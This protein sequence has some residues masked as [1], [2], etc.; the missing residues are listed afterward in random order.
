[1][2]IFNFTATLKFG[3]CLG[4]VFEINLYTGKILNFFNEYS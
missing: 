1:M 3:L 4:P 2:C